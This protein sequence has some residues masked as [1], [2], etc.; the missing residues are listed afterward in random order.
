MKRI[1]TSICDYIVAEV[2]EINIKNSTKIGMI[3][4]LV[5]LSKYH[6]NKVTF[7]QIKN[8][9]ILEFLNNLRR[10]V[11]KD[12]SQR[13]IG[14]FNG[15][16]I[17]LNKFFKWLYNPEEPNHTRNLTP[18]CMKSIKPLSRK[19]KTPFKPSDLGTERAFYLLKILV[20]IS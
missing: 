17:I 5:R 2:T 16:L 3:K 4:I 14:S 19:E 15:R 1:P 10:Q 18:E 12:P 8:Q 11:V 13:W 7:K 6:D 20:Q 9:D